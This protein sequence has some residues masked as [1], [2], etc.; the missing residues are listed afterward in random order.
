MVERTRHISAFNDARA[1]RVLK[2]ASKHIGLHSLGY[3][4]W[5]PVLRLSYVFFF[6]EPWLCP[7]TAIMGNQRLRR[8]GTH[9]HARTQTHLHKHITHRAQQHSSTTPHHH[10]P[11]HTTPHYT[12]P[13][14][15]TPDHTTPHQTMPQHTTSHHTTRHHETPHTATTPQGRPSSWQGF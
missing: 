3:D 13:Q 2:F 4:P 12:T 5:V 14:H 10:T 9:T 11:H 1:P 15:T 6:Y 8:K 7:G